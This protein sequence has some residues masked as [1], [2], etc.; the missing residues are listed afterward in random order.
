MKKSRVC[1]TITAFLLISFFYDTQIVSLIA[2][3][4]AKM[5]DWLMI[6]LTNP[7]TIITVFLLMTTLFLWEERKRRWIIPMWF[8]IASVDVITKIIKFIVSR[9]RPFEALKL[10]IIQGASYNFAIWDASFPSAH[11]A[12]VFSLVPILDKEFPKLKWF[13]ITLAALIAFSRV[14]I[15]V[16]YP[17]D[18]LAGCLLGLLIGHGVIY[19]EKKYNPFRK[20]TKKRS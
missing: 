17:S 16:H 15:G 12:V 11:A 13:W 6:W 20:W 7:L 9:P 19:L 3:N 14:Y 10:P 4:R 18:V 8:T 5:L 1:I 2:Q